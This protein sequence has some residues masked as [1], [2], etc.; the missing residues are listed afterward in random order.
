MLGVHHIPYKPLGRCSV[1]ELAAE[2]AARDRR[3]MRLTGGVAF[4][5]KDDDQDGKRA[6]RSAIA[7]MLTLDAMPGCISILTM[8]G[9]G[10]HFEGKLLKLREPNWRT[11]QMTETMRL[12]CVENDRFIYYSAATRMPGKHTLMR[13]LDRPDYAER[14]MGNGIID[15]YEFANVDDVMASGET[16]DVAWLDYTGPLTVER[17]KLIEHF[18]R[19]CVR[20]TLIVT[21]LKA[22]WNK[23]VDR[24]AK[25][26]GGYCEWAVSPFANDIGLHAIEYQDGPSPMFQFALR[27]P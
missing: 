12:T 2:Q 7:D 26:H 13:A 8:P 10:W 18:Y 11:Q 25:R 21:V 24:A 9:V 22:R 27:K 5:R 3:A 19:R 16:F 15:R 23:D 6:A 1:E 20:S 4:A 14:V 17:L